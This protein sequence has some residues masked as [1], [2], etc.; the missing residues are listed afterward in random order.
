MKK[1]GRARPRAK[2]ARAKEPRGPEEKAGSGAKRRVPKWGKWAAIGGGALL[3]GVTLWLYVLYPASGG[4]NEGREAEVVI[5]SEDTAGSIADKLEEAGL[6]SSPRLFAFYVS[7]SGGAGGI[8]RGSH[9]LSDDASP[10]EL[11]ARLERRASE[12]RVKVIFPEGW[13]RFQMAK[14]LE[15]KRICRLRAFLNATLDKDL[16]KR[17][18]V[19]GDSMEGYLFP[20]TYELAPDSDPAAVVTQMKEEFERRFSAVEQRHASQVADLAR[21]HKFGTREIVVLAS[22]VEKEAAVDEDRP[23][24]A[25]V[26]LNR[27]GAD[28]G[29]APKFLN[30]DPTAA[31]GC[32]LLKA[33]ELA[34]E[35]PSCAEYAGKPTPAINNDLRNPYGTYKKEGLPPGPIA[36]PGT[37][38]LEA[39]MGAPVT[40]F[41]YFVAVGGDRRHTFSETLGAHTA[42]IRDGGRR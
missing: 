11:L 36:N 29:F 16:M 32:T 23:L 1:G 6:L 35:I 27:L 19:E 17:L 5:T 21:T 37:K 39:V 38:S 9:F 26:F 10:G 2:E 31:Y 24:I 22:L 8:V 4:P 30:C 34:G 33:G 12:R 42:V 15:E 28:L 20:A 18:R 41:L 14:R 25:S 3:F 7:L 13:N 40:R